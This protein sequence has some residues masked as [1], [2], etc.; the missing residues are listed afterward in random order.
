MRRVHPDRFP[1]YQLPFD[2]QTLSQYQIQSTLHEGVETI[3][4]RGHTPDRPESTILKVLKAEYPSL[5]AITRLKHEYQ[6]RQNLNHPQIIKFLNIENFNHR[7]AL[8]LEDI[9]GKS[10]NLVLSQSKIAI[11]NFLSIAIQLTKALDY[12][13]KNQIIHKDI[14]PSNIIINPQTDIVKLT[15]FGIASRLTKENPLFNNPNS[16]EGTLAYM[17]PEQTGRM[18]R[19]LDYRTDFY[20]LGVTFYE[21]LTGQLPFESNDTLEIVYKHIASEPIPAQQLNPEIPTAISE[22]LLKLMAKNAED[23]YQ[24]A[25]GLLSDLEICLN[26]LQTYGEITDFIPGCLDVLSQLLIPQ[27]LYGREQQVNELLAAFER[28]ATGSPTSDRLNQELN[29]P[30][31]LILVSGYSGIGK[32]AVVNE[33]NKP[34]TRLKGYFISGKFDQFKR[35]I[36]YTSFSQA[37]GTLMRQILTEPTAKIQEW[38]DK[39]ITALES[40]RQLI[41]DII[42]EVELIIGKQP[43]DKN[44]LNSASTNPTESQN[45]FNRAFQEF[46]RVFTKPKHPLVIFLDDLQWADSATLKLMEILVTDP[47]SKYLLFV[48]A[49]RDNEVSP[50]HPLMQTID[51]IEKNGTKINNI[52]LQ[53]LD[54]A[55]TTQLI[56]DTLNHPDGIED[57]ANL[58]SDNTEGNPFFL[59]Q[60]LQEIYQENLLR[61]DFGHLNQ[62][63]LRG[64]KGRWQWDLE[65]IKTI[66]ITDKSV[67]KLVVRRIQQL[68]ESTQL[69]LKLAACMGDKFTLN[70]LSIVS[71]Q[72]A[73]TIANQLDPALQMGLIVPLNNDYKIPIVFKEVLWLD[74][75]VDTNEIAVSQID[76]I[77]SK[78]AEVKYKFLHDRVQQAAYSM[79]PELDKQN[80][81]LKI[82]QLLLIHIPESEIEENIFELVNHLNIGANLLSDSATKTKV[83]ELNLIA[84]EKAK[85]ANA[86]E[87]AVKYLNAGLGL[88]AEDSWIHDYELTLSLYV[89]TM[90]AEYLN[91]NYQQAK[92]LIDLAIAQA[93]TVLDLVKIYTKKI[94]FY[95]SQGNFA[96]A[97]DTGI[98]ILTMLGTHLPTDSESLSQMSQNLRSQLIFDT[99]QIAKLADL[100]LMEDPVKLAATNILI[101]IIP[102]VYF[103]KPEL[104][105]PVILSM[106][107]L[108]V[109]YGNAA[110]STFGYCLYGMLLCSILDDIAAGYEFGKLSL[111]VLDKFPGNPIK[112]QV[113]KTFTSHIQPWKEPLRES[114]ANLIT[115]IKIGLETGNSE[116]TSYGSAEYCM[117]LFLS[118]EN[119]EIVA[120]KTAYYEVLLDNLKLEFGM[121]YLRI[122]R[123]VVLNLAGESQNNCILTGS[124]FSEE[125]MLP[126]IVAAN[127]RLLIFCFHLF[128]LILF[129]LF[130]D[131]ESAII[132]ADKSTALVDSVLGMIYIAEHNFY[133]SL[134]LLANYSAQSAIDQQQSLKIVELNQKKMQMW[135]FHAPM[136]FQHK[137]DLVSAEKARVLNQSWAAME[138][139]DSAIAGAKAQGYIQE[140]ALANELA[141]EFYLSCGRDKIAKVYLTDAY[142]AYI[143]WGA[144]AKVKDLAS[145]YNFLESQTHNQEISDHDAI[146]NTSGSTSSESFSSAL[147]LASFIKFSQAI[148][149]EIVLENLLSKLIEIL[150][151]NSAAQKALLLLQKDQKLYIEAVGNATEEVPNVLQSIPVENSQNLPLSVVN[152]VLHTQENLLLNNATIAE[153]FNADTYIQKIQTRSI[154]CVPILYQSQLQGIIYLE[155]NLTVGAFTQDRVEVLNVLISQAA[156][157]IINAQL[158]AQVRESESQLKQFF[159]AIPVAVFITNQWGTP[160]YANESAKQILGKGIVYTPSAQELLETYQA[161][162]AGSDKLYPSDRAPIS[163]ALQGINTKLDDMEIRHSGKNIPIEVLATPI[164]DEDGNVAYAIA[165]FSDITERKQ[166]EAEREN[167]WYEISQLNCELAEANEQLEQYSQTLEQKVAERTAALQA[168]Q[169]QIIAQEKLSSLGILTA[170]VAHE[171]RNP[172]NFVN[173]YAE[174]SV[175][176]TEELLAEI[177]SKSKHLDADSIDYITEMLTDI[178]ENAAAIHDH[179]QRADSIIH[180]MMQHARSDSGNHQPTD[181]NALLDQA[182]NLAYQIRR[183]SDDRFNVIICKDYDENL[184]QWDVVPSDLNRAFINLIDN[185][186]YA[187]CDRQKYHQQQ[188]DNQQKKFTRQLWIK[189][190]NLGIFAEIRI[191][192]NGQGIPAEIMDKIFNPFFTTKPTGEG[193]GLGLS[194]THDIIIGQ[195]GGTLQV[196]T[197]PGVYTEF[198]IKLPKKWSP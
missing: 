88:L 188:A 139:Y 110:S 189:T 122:S 156:I 103:V 126:V 193:M 186:C 16:I 111:Q 89:A 194:L 37:L 158:Y 131:S 68:P 39:I 48:G 30:V 136:N 120:R 184:G 86:Y 54:L 13:H 92:I 66:G 197:E 107:N 140:E 44:S 82:G 27:K 49:Y 87:T 173:N 135:A 163:K 35:N 50:T 175:E 130:K 61:F 15:D 21:I 79:I 143:R 157:A 12:L 3:V 123:Q 155:N 52:V 65:E 53:P 151:E 95:I 38:R 28:I 179:G 182:V 121:F 47:E 178:K 94:Q 90:E 8:L 102:P 74:Q 25:G 105:V 168:A 41:V 9:G 98:E 192:D 160:Y 80:T 32:S 64:I 56:S 180:S 154:L 177:D 97:I 183:V 172:L 109:N 124:S 181:L 167:Y 119:L 185:A 5:Q 77:K 112:C 24:S 108:A 104:L 22:I 116:F 142:Y 85:S 59:N 118:G 2:M 7:T 147:D 149:S 114:I 75:K 144:M 190:Q 133:H 101:T 55:N 69:A 138:Y 83:A 125:T 152:Y 10:L 19:T 70:V 93:K 176:L 36:P 18:N 73:S 46:I 71:E 106:V 141:G 26:C 96:S 146:H 67:V 115:A 78:I 43:S 11:A 198:I 33:I 76:T 165:A 34:I 162:L 63:S 17:S 145:R 127:Y 29:K 148:A 170:G 58:I 129:Y 51:E 62:P 195:H 1:H 150:L 45:R 42:P 174:V 40:N 14:K 169:K 6:I 20:S 99:S 100:P 81:H 84:G 57:L 166:H 23:R 132:E 134:S 117:Y 196:D 159:D 91:T 60:F 161:Y 187:V 153:P 72:S 137:Y 113:Y 31:P 128:K 4:Y 164:Y 171:L 191:R